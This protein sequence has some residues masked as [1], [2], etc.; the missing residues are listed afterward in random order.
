MLKTCWA[1]LLT[2]LHAICARLFAT[3]TPEAVAWLNAFPQ[4]SAGLRMDNNTV[5]IATGLRL[6][7]L[8]CLPHLCHHCGSLVASF[9]MYGHRCR[10]S[11]GRHSVL[12]Y[13]ICRFLVSAGSIP[14]HLKPQNMFRSDGKRPNIISVPWKYGKLL[15]WDA[16]HPSSI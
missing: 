8:L 2:Q 6:G 5:R 16:L 7:A 13:I 10:Y 11:E 4:H 9:A 12:N 3:S 1:A 15:L 14:A